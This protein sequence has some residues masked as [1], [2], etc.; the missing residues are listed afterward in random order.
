RGYAALRDACRP[1]LPM[2]EPRAGLVHVVSEHRDEL[3]GAVVEVRGGGRRLGCFTGDIAAD[4]ATYVGRVELD[5]VAEACV[6]VEHP[7][8]GA[9][10]NRYEALLLA[11][12][13]KEPQR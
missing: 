11:S 2:I 8:I 9:I 5:G 3:P 10:E 6:A 7:S 12:V 13:R 1:V 4:A